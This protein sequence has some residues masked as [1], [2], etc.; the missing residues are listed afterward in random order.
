MQKF[1][2][3]KYDE[4]NIELLQKEFNTI[5]QD[6]NNA[7]TVKE[8]I[9]AVEKFETMQSDISTNMSVASIR[10]DINTTDKYYSKQ[11]D[12]I[13]EIS[14]LL[15]GCINEFYKALIN[16][17]FKDKLVKHYGQRIF[18]IAEVALKSFDP[19][20]I[21]DL[22]EENKLTSKYRKLCSSA[23]IKFRGKTYNLAGLG[24]LMSDVDRKTRSG[25]SKAYYSFFD[26]HLEE[27]DE[28][29]D[30]LVH[31]RDKMAKK[32]GYSNFVDFRYLQLGRT[33]YGAEDVKNYRD[34]VYKYV[35]PITKKIFKKQANHLKIKGMQYYDYNL[36][37]LS[38]NPFPRG[39][40]DELVKA[41]IDMYDDMS[42]ETS[43]FFRMMVDKHLMDLEAKANKAGGGYCTT[44]PKY[45]A[46]YI[47]ANFNGTSGD[48][49][50]LTHEVGHAF[51]GYCCQDAQLLEYIW[52]TCEACEIHSMSM[53]FFAYPYMNAFFG[54]DTTKYIYS[55]LADA[56]TFIPYGVAVDEFQHFVYENVDVTPAER[57][58]KWREIEKKYLPHIKY[59]NNKFLENGGRFMRQAHIYESPFYYI[60]YTIAQ[61][62]AFQFFNL[63]NE[64]KTKAW[65]KYLNLCKLG[66]SKS[67]LGLLKAVKLDNPFKKGCI[68]KVIKPVNVF[69]NHIDSD[70]L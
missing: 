11:R 46:P 20:I 23:K 25:A 22:I 34:Q 14:P 1:E 8:Q 30:K 17:K 33:D 64:D 66:G 50:V 62:C 65:E 42:P 38:G 5:L 28:I 43:K 24:K 37:F 35:V 40:K 26:K 21:E 54:E 70:N 41:A 51:M 4:M 58:A 69:L 55:H 39:N 15:N 57:R 48:V 56:V 52:P 44:L 68:K 59:K 3:F 61:V 6:F 19:I 7:K 16:S 45:K 10:F 47:F 27:F 31:V 32:L 2:D 67:F 36:K 49:D 13:D 18:D 29:Y 53:E 9:A 60:D 12:V 63:M